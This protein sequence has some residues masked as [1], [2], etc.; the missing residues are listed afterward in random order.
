MRTDFP[1][2]A[3]ETKDLAFRLVR[4]LRRSLRDTHGRREWTTRNLD[5]L[6]SFSDDKYELQHFPPPGFNQKGAF[7]WDY[8]AYQQNSGI[9][10]AAETEFESKPQ[11]L[12]EDFEKLLYVRSPIKVFLFWLMKD[13]AAFESVV[14]DLT[15]CMTLCSEY[16]PG[17]IF[18]LYCRT[19]ANE[20][21]S[22]GDIARWLQIDGEPCRRNVRG[23]VFETVPD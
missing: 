2:T 10:I 15:E 12:K 20:D 4:H 23:K 13:Q 8:I 11:K 16:S 3:A 21:A 7:L 14:S 1:S 9:L 19:W 5:A 17:E 18:I 6:R 22:S